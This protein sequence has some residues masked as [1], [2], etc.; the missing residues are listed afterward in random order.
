MAP[1][2]RVHHPRNTIRNVRTVANRPMSRK[3]PPPF[4]RPQA[5]MTGKGQ[6]KQPPE[7]AGPEEPRR[8]RRKPIRKKPTPTRKR[9]DG[10]LHPD[11]P[12]STESSPLT[13]RL[14]PARASMAG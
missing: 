9:T 5:T 10:N 8:T 3:D 14:V 12:F 4:P 13:E 11:E 6:K 7:I 1:G 2:F